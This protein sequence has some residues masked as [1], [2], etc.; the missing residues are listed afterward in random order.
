[1]K[2]KSAIN[3][4][5]KSDLSG[6]LRKRDLVEK[7]NQLIDSLGINPFLSNFEVVVNVRSKDGLYRSDDGLLLPVEYEYERD[8]KVNVYTSSE[9]RRVIGN[10]SN[11]G[12]SLYLHLIYEVEYGCDYIELNVNRYMIENDI[13]SL[14]TY[15]S[16]VSDL[17]KYAIIQSVEGYK[18]IFW[19]NP[20]YF[21]AGSRVST[22]KKYVIPYESKR[23][24]EVKDDMR[25][26]S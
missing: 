10:L 1:M 14:N 18:N 6:E 26:I 12:K 22:F 16:G 11:S 9:C 25:G 5:M 23:D 2:Y 8:S 4:M 17:K 15:K 13:S 20:R 21:F 3:K 7:K 24:K 19:I